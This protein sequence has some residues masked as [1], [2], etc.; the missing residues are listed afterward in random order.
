MKLPD[1]NSSA[2]LAERDEAEKR[3]DRYDIWVPNKMMRSFLFDE[4]TTQHGYPC[5]W[6]F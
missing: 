2:L 1:T 5:T 4:T 6:S 3:P